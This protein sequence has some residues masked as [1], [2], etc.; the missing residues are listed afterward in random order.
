[1]LFDLS[2]PGD[3][4][5]DF[6]KAAKSIGRPVNASNS[7][8]GSTSHLLVA[9][10]GAQAGLDITPVSNKGSAP[11]AAAVMQGDVD[12]TWSGVSDVAPIVSSNRVKILAVSSEKRISSHPNVPSVSDTLPGFSLETWNGYFGPP[13]TPKSIVDLVAKTVQDAGK[14]PEI[15]QKLVD[16]GIEP[17][18]T[19]PSE[20]AAII[21]SDKAFY[22]KTVDSAGLK[23]E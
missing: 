12:M 22:K 9:A 20:T 4:L 3:N 16:L 11:S 5:A 1:M 23:P 2:F 13:G 6:I 7:G 18:T 10:F 21:Q 19:T 14:A 17:I 15:R 8:Y